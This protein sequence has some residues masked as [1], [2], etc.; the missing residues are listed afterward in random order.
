[1]P[2]WGIFDLFST[3]YV[4]ISE[5]ANYFNPQ[6]FGSGDNITTFAVPKKWGN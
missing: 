2:N 3:P 6:G 4:I 1:M 5:R